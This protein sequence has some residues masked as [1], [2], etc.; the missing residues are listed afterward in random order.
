MGICYYNF[1][2]PETFVVVKRLGMRANLSIFVNG[3][4]A[5]ELT[6]WQE[7]LRDF[8]GFFVEFGKPIFHFH[9]ACK[10]PAGILERIGTPNGKYVMS[11]DFE[12]FSVSYL[13]E[14]IAMRKE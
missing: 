8:L 5:G 4:L 2:K 7:E 12:T 14:I 13:R 9:Y 6:L 11:D 3:A 10:G 1:K